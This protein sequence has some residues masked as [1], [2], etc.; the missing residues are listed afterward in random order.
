MKATTETDI[1]AQARDCL[2]RDRFGGAAP[3]DPVPPA[4][5]REPPERTFADF[6]RD[7]R[8]LLLALL[9][10]AAATVFVFAV[11][12][13]IAGLGETLKRLG[14]G[15]KGW[16]A[17]GLGFEVLSIAGYVAVFRAVFCCEGVEIGWSEN[18]QITLA[19]IVATKIFAAAGAG[20]VALTAWA[21]RASGLSGRTVARR[22][23]AL[24]ILL[25]GVY[26]AALVIFGLG[27][28][29]GLF[30]GDS[31]ASLT[32]V[33]AAFGATVIALVLASRFLPGD[34]GRRLR[35]FSG[36]SERRR[37]GLERVSAVPATLRDGIATAI[38]LLRRPRPGLAGAILYWAFDIA[39][40]WATFRAFGGSPPVAVVVMAYY[41]GTLANLIPIPGGIGGVEGGMIG[42]FIAFGVNGS[43]AVLAVLSYR[44][45]SF[46]LPTLPGTVAYFQLRQ[47]V[48]RWRGG[49]AVQPA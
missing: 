30:G 33:P 6:V 47:T 21:L 32:L 43:T 20:G 42:C 12:P 38:A 10:A 34:I 40:L 15:S 2:G 37:R 23:T 4:E 16:L 39:T 49:E 11:L 41:V 27:L 31:P 36:G 9:A 29:S 18:Y 44:A 28:A 5:I 3:E 24:E 22:M 19:G 17:L 7:H 26:M 45:L 35:R 8:R 1:D 14:H 25:Y 48:G 13:Q 46:W